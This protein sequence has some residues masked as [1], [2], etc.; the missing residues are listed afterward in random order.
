M[1]MQ[2]IRIVVALALFTGVIKLA[3]DHRVKQVLRAMK[4]DLANVR[5][6]RGPERASLRGATT[7]NVAVGQLALTEHQL[8]FY[9]TVG[10]P[11]VLARAEIAGARPEKWFR[12]ARAI[13]R[14]HL[15]VKTTAGAEYGF[16]VRDPDGWIKA[17]ASRSG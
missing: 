3:V 7:R 17:L 15:V 16:M 14:P 12:H 2:I 1:T 11:V 4:R 8:M 9:R 6:E 5:I 13:G 10:D